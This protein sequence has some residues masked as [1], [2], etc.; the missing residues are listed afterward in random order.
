ML[1]NILY[2]LTQ[3]SLLCGIAAVI[4][5]TIFFP[6][7]QRHGLKI[8]KVSVFLS[9]GFNVLFYNKS[10]YPSLFNMSAYTS[11]AYFIVSLASYNILAR[12]SKWFL[13]EK[14]E[15]ANPYAF[16]FLSLLFCYTLLMTTT[17]WLILLIALFV[18][19]FLQY[20]MLA[21]SSQS[22]ELY[23]LS[24]RYGICVLALFS[25]IFCLLAYMAYQH[26]G[27]SADIGAL[28]NEK[29]K[30]FLCVALLLM[31]F[32][33]MGI[34][35]FHFAV[36]DC[37]SHTSLPISFYFHLVPLIAV[38]TTFLK[39]QPLLFSLQGDGLYSLYLIFGIMSVFIAVIGV[40]ATCFIKKILASIHLYILGIWFIFLSF[41]PQDEM[42]TSLIYLTGYLISVLGVDTCLY[43]FRSVAEDS[44]DLNLYAG[45]FSSR[46]YLTSAFILF[47]LSLSGL[48]PFLGFVT[49]LTVFKALAVSP[50]MV[51]MVIITI[52]LMLPVYLKIIYTVSFLPKKQT[53]AR[54]D[55]STYVWLVFYAGLVIFL[56]LRPIFFFQ[57]KNFF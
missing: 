40:H 4:F 16:L 34:A 47:V 32:F 43:Y 49:Q 35:P 6:S 51:Y 10:F 45:L 12:S 19:C 3:I 7:S 2:A 44:D 29:F 8:A 46:P 37:I 33:M 9:C 25:F 21:L 13:R 57:I 54:V 26:Y 5:D 20:K 23:H 30:T 18:I 1:E 50:L 53:F 22:E 42:I 14:Q 48:P 31:F 41:H 38:G 39:Q 17:N 36:F 11:L 27:Y 56:M 15:S 52:L 28:T 24:R 55:F